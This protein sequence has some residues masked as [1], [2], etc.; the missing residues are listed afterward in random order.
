MRSN[1]LHLYLLLSK[2]NNKMGVRIRK[3]KENQ[4]KKYVI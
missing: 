3:E 2:I 4:R 1:Y